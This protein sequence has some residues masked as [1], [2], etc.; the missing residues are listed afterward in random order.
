M[1]EQ[2]HYLDVEVNTRYIAEQ[3]DP[4][5][6][7]FVFAYHI[8]MTNCGTEPI[9]LIGRHWYITDGKNTVQEVRGEGVVGEQPYLR[10][11][12]SYDYTSGAVLETDVG[13]MEGSYQMRADSGDTFD[14][15]IAAFTLARPRALH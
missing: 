9:Q 13:M 14:A 7:R 1:N 8:T 12:E 10:V 3:S 11:G 4:D 2:K 15:P 5:Q 6:R